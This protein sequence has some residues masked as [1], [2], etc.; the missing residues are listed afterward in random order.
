MRYITSGQSHGK[1]LFSIIEGMPSGL[2]IDKSVIDY[3][4]KLRQS[5]YGR[6]ARQNIESDEVYIQTG[7]RGGYTM[8]SPITLYLPNKDYQNWQEG[9]DENYGDT[10]L[11]P[12]NKIRPGHADLSGSIK[13]Q[14]N[15]ARNI[16]ERASARE[17]AIRVAS[18]ALARQYLSALG[19]EIEGYVVSVY[20]A[21]DRD[22]YT[23]EQLKECKKSPLFM[24]N[25]EVENR[26]VKNIDQAAL[27]G[28]SVG[29]VV[30]IRVHGLKV[31]FGSCMQYESKLDGILCGALMSIQSIKGV[32]VGM[33]FD[34]ASNMGSQ[35]HDCLYVE[36]N[37]IVRHT[38]NAGGIEGGMSNGEDII[39]RLAVKP[40]PTLK[41]G[42]P[43]VDISTHSPCTAQSERGD[44]CAI[45]AVEIIAESVVAIELSKVIAQ[46]LGGDTIHE[47]IER[48][49]ALKDM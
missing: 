21:V 27:L 33:G 3:Y 18:G 39:L 19:V 17:T 28:D 2:K 22:E 42:L 20:D 47:V 49:N 24:L 5:G 29:G 14:L 45:C 1:G 43:S 25:K 23:F 34:V 48:Y 40:I 13:Y 36:N 26:A 46:R 44:I 32:E 38:N 35:V 4:L 12:L 8:G 6:G 9:M 31:G 7:V 16:S 10:N 41:K 30:E 11:Y 15:D 37:S